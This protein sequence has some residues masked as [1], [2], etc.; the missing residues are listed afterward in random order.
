MAP[1]STRVAFRKNYLPNL[2]MEGESSFLCSDTSQQRFSRS[3]IPERETSNYSFCSPFL[4]LNQVTLA[5]QTVDRTNRQ[6]LVGTAHS[7][8]LDNDTNADSWFANKE[9]FT[10]SERRISITQWVGQAWE[11]LILA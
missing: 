2:Y 4:L 6:M 7:D 10:A 3:R 9:P 5:A 8:R 1:K 11:K